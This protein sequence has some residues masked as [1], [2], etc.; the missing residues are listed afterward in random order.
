MSAY[1]VVRFK[2]KP[3]MQKA[4]EDA[5]RID[6]DFEGFHGGAL[7]KTGEDTYCFVGCW[8]NFDRIAAAR[9]KMIGMLDRFR[10]ML[11]DLGGG[12][13]V[14]DPAS[15]EAVVEFLCGTNPFGLNPFETKNGS[16]HASG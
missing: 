9:P 13:G 16:F 7:V 15:G 1:N 12:K 3:G 11:E 8:E 2:V 6:P 14:T 10:P 4:F 5:H